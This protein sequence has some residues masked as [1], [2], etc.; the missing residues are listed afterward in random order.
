MSGF[1]AE[2]GT[3]ADTLVR[4]GGV[5]VGGIAAGGGQAATRRSGGA[6]SGVVRP[7]AAGSD[8]GA[9]ATGVSRDRP[10][11][12][13]RW[14]PDDRDGDLR[15]VDGAQ[16]ALPVGVSTDPQGQDRQAQRIR[17]CDPAG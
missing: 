13:D 2:R 16:G 15:P 1:L 12:V 6:G 7:A 11:G 17:V 9:V 5:L 14:A 10:A 4:P 8:R 3:Y